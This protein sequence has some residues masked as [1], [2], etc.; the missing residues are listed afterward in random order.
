MEP[1]TVYRCPL[2]NNIF[3]TM[4]GFEDHSGPCQKKYDSGLAD[5][6]SRIYVLEHGWGDMLLFPIRHV[7]GYVY[8]NGLNISETG[9]GLGV[10]F[11]D[12]GM[13]LDELR[14]YPR[15]DMDRAT[16]MFDSQVADMRRR[17]LHL[18]E[19]EVFL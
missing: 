10:E 3:E 11:T 19:R 2:C 13:S 12:T 7:A 8:C 4:D 17:L 15:I 5:V 9:S 16:E 1:K 18:A 14:R 6:M